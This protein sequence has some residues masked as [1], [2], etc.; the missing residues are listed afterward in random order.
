MKWIKTL[1]P[2]ATMVLAILFMVLWILDYFNPMM[3]FLTSPLPKALMMALLVCTIANGILT[4]YYQR[5]V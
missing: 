1:L 4:V 2:H 5:N 3:Q